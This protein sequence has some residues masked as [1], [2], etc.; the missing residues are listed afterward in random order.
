MVPLPVMLLLLESCSSLVGRNLWRSP[1]PSSAQVVYQ[2]KFLLRMSGTALEQAAQGGGG[3]TVPGGGQEAWRCST[4][5]R[6]LMVA[7]VV[8]QQFN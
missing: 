5:G 3:V 2:E 8:G 4:E 1:T 6:G 7:E